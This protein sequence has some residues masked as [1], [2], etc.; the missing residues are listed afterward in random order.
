MSSLFSFIKQQVPI[1]QEVGRYVR[2]RHAGSYLKGSCPFHK[3]TDASFT[4][5]PDKG[6]FYC[7]GC[8][9]TGDVVSFIAK[10]EN[11]SPFE[12][13]KQLIETHGLKV[14]EELMKSAASGVKH[15]EEKASYFALHKY[16]AVWAHQQLRMHKHAYDYVLARGITE[17]MIDLFMIGFFP[18]GSRAINA[19]LS[20]AMKENILAKD[21]MEAGIFYDSGKMQLHSPFE[22][23]V[24]FPITDVMG[25]FCGFGGRVFVANDDRA[26]YYNSKESPFFVKG[27]LLFGY[28]VAK[29]SMQER[30]AVFLVEGY[31]DC[32]MMAQYGYTN[33]VATLGTACTKEHLQ[34]LA[35]S[36][37][38]VYVIYDGDNAGRKA[39]LRLANLCWQVHLELQVI[40]LP[41]GLDPAAYLKQC[42]S[43]AEVLPQARDIF[44]FFVSATADEFAKKNLAEKM[45][46]IEDV[47]EV[48]AKISDV[49]KREVLLQQLSY[50]VDL[51][52]TA[53]RMKLHEHVR[54][55]VGADTASRPVQISSEEA[56]SN[57]YEALDAQIVAISLNSYVQGTPHHLP[58]DVVAMLPH[59]VR[60]V[61]E[62]MVAQQQTKTGAA[63]IDA[64]L[65]QV[66]SDHRQWLTAALTFHGGAVNEQEFAALINKVVQ[67]RWK[68]IVGQIR[69]DIAQ[70]SASGDTE[71]VEELLSTFA[72]WKEQIQQK[73]HM[74]WQKK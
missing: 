26:K 54:S 53:L 5:S 15:G 46:I 41:N 13:A 44:T 12:A 34:L 70:A 65:A 35:R 33:V 58:D 28:S 63:L 47:L 40:T 52:L 22:D 19:L 71:K 73:G 50:A 30:K 36:V 23:R 39:M 24:V 69:H 11:I 45:R 20:G 59:R 56:A 21:L 10:V 74:L 49:V 8:H 31:T 4:V 38:L 43:L 62:I 2:L 64:V 18:S 32:V 6:I 37:E 27:S 29:K 17:Q 68:E 57:D 7:F 3:E 48:I 1:V 25:R 16:I 66:S 55:Q 42:H 72:Q 60:L 61:H 67:Q 51:P 14:P 9:A